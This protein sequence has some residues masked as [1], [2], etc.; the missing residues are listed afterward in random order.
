MTAGIRGVKLTT[1]EVKSSGELAYEVGRYE[2]PGADSK[3][4]EAG[5]YCVVWRRLT[6]AW[7]LHRDIWNSMPAEK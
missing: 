3:V 2:L 4:I 1:D 6:G 5:N 7:Q